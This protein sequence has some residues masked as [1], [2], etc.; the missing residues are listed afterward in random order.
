MEIQWADPTTFSEDLR[1][2]RK[3]RAALATWRERGTIHDITDGVVII[4]HSLGHNPGQN[5]DDEVQGTAVH[6][7]AIE[8]LT[9]FKPEEKGESV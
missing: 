8:K 9:V 7:D 1:D 6:E 4:A 5:E 3:G 2:L